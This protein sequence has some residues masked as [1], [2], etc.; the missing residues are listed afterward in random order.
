M[1]VLPPKVPRLDI[2]ETAGI[3]IP[4]GAAQLVT[5]NVWTR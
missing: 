3:S 5:V 1:F 4:V 2:I